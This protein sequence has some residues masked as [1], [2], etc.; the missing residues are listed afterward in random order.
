MCDLGEPALAVIGDLHVS[1]T[2]GDH[3]PR[4]V[5]Q[6]LGPSTRCRPGRRQ[7]SAG[8]RSAS[9]RSPLYDQSVV[10]QTEIRHLTLHSASHTI[11]PVTADHLLEAYV[12]SISTPGKL[13]RAVRHSRSDGC[14]ARD[15]RRDHPPRS[16]RAQLHDTGPHHRAGIRGDRGRRDP[17]YPKRRHPAPPPGDRRSLLR[18]VGQGDHAEYGHG[19]PW[20][21]ER[22]QLDHLRPDRSWR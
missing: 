18:Q 1:V 13:D 6:G 11:P 8:P 10:C 14:R 20:R 19:Q 5:E 22:D 17:L 12:R 7:R 4:R 2:I 3:A 9:S 21:R 16:R 15:G